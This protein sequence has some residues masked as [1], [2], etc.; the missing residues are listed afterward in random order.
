MRRSARRP[1]RALL[2]SVRRTVMRCL[3]MADQKMKGGTMPEVTTGKLEANDYKNA[4][5]S[6]SA[7]NLSGIV[8]E[9][10]RV[11]SKIWNEAHELG[12]GTEWVNAHPIARLYA[13]QIFHLAA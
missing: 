5:F 12:F 7:C 3:M 4:V 1:K 6:Q 10:S 11:I 2:L 9:L 13:E 8:H